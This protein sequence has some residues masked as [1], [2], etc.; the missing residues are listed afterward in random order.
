MSKSNLRI[1][2][3][4]LTIATAVIHL[5]LNLGGIQIPFIINAIGYVVLLALFFKWVN[6]AFMQGREK[7]LWYVFMG[8]TA[9][10]I[11]LYFVVNIPGGTAF[12]MPVGLVDKAIEVLLIIALWLHKEA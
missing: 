9:L 8:Y 4:V 3:I 2:I 10:T 7:M 12:S 1:A 11:V 6:V 5:L